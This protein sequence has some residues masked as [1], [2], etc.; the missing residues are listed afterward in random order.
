MG[1]NLKRSSEKQ[2][3]ADEI[4]NM[5]QKIFDIHV[6][7]DRY[8]VADNKDK[9]FRFYELKS[10]QEKLEKQ[11]NNFCNQY[12][13]LVGTQ[14]GYRTL[15]NSLITLG[16]LHIDSPKAEFESVYHSFEESE[17]LLL[18]SLRK[19]FAPQMPK[20]KSIGVI[21]GIDGNGPHASVNGTVEFEPNI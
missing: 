7:L 13:H 11:C 8:K 5:R 9:S 20:L 1:N 14:K 2:I 12:M 17:Q 3:V 4:Q 18:D 16:S 6:C 21:A 10:I 15:S 19:H